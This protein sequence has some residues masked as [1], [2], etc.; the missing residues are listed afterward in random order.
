MP[1]RRVKYTLLALRSSLLELMRKKDISRITVKELCERADV[2]RGTFYAHY[3][4]PVDLLEQI[5][6]ELLE[7]VLSSLDSK[8]ATGSL[9][10]LLTDI[11]TTLQQNGDLCK[12]L[13]S[14]HGDK[15]FLGRV[16]ETAREPCLQEWQRTARDLPRETLD[17]LY[18]FMANGSVG[19]I[20]AW[21]EED[22]RTEP[23]VIARFIAC[24]SDGALRAIQG[25]GKPADGF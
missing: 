9:A 2:N 23:A 10:A 1:D 16:M 3:A 24:L 6:R 22:M 15:E 7:E 21:I 19:V 11:F 14:E 20:R 17:L 8:L 25:T 5:E 12:V 13:F 4:S 18:S